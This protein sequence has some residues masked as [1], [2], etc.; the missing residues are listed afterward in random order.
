[1]NL[2]KGL[3][4]LRRH[5]EKGSRPTQAQLVDMIDRGELPGKI[6]DGKP[7]VDENRFIGSGPRVKKPV[8]KPSGIELLS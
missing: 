5:F 8:Q 3:V 7:Y 2:V 1:M 4:F 6:L